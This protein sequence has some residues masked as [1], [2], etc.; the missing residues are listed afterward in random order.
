MKVRPA[1]LSRAKCI[2]Y[3]RDMK[4]GEP[5]CRLEYDRNLLMAVRIQKNTPVRNPDTTPITLPRSKF[6]IM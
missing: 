5:L 6:H 2:G 4:L 1:T 3:A